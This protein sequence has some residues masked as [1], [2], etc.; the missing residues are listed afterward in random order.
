ML[1]PGKLG[2]SQLVVVRSLGALLEGHTVPL[3]SALPAATLHGDGP[4]EDGSCGCP[5]LV[6]GVDLSKTLLNI[7]K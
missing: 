1:G 5:A 3:G 7:G 4:H 2:F 6:L